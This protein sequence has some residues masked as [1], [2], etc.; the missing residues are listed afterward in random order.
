MTSSGVPED[1]LAGLTAMQ[2]EAARQEGPVV[3]LAGAGTGKTKTLVAGVVDRIVRRG[4][5]AH[6][7]LA[8]TFTNKAADEM[9]TRINA[10]L[11]LGAALR[12]LARFTGMV[13]ASCGLIP[14]LRC[15]GRASASAMPRTAAGLSS[16]CYN[17]RL[18]TG[19]GIRVMP[20]R[21]VPACVRL[22]NGL[23]S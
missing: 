3:V 14:R 17:G 6:R 9:R 1:A 2:R 5:P 19:H 12:G 21:S 23:L 11:G 7:I 8:V 16:A 10:V 20:T 13:A 15:C 18:M 22:P 4:M